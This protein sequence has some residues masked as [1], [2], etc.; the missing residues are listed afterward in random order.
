MLERSLCLLH[1]IVPFIS[2][3]LWQRL[4]HKG[5]TISLAEY[6][7]A[8]A[9]QLD[10][11]AEREMAL[12]FDLITRLRSIR[13]IFNIA[14]SVLLEA[15]VAP[16]DAETR[17]VI[18]QMGDHIARLAR[19]SGLHFVDAISSQRGAAR[20][21]VNG[22]EIEVPL[23]GLIDFDKERVR[24]ESELAKLQGE[25]EGLERR[26]ANADF[27]S[28]AAA[29]VVASTRARSVELDGQVARLRVM[30]DSL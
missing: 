1:P 26:L 28:R 4:P 7:I 23:Q 22:A 25:R 13:S 20:A 14:P 10:G 19:L 17:L 24:L 5:E 6:P 21:V 30:I 8:N 9:A 29:E 27:V 18:E 16:A 15:R 2:E 11:R 3:E 12:V